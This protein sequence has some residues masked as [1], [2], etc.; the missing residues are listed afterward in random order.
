MSAPA[1]ATWPP[2]RSASAFAGASRST[3]TVVSSSRKPS[4]TAAAASAAIRSGWSTRF[5]TCAWID[6][7]RRTRIF[8]IA[9]RISTG[10]RSA[11][12]AA[13][14][15]G[16]MP[17]GQP[18]DLGARNRGIDDHPRELDRVERHR[19]LGHGQVDPVAGDELVDQVELLL[20]LPV[21]LDHAALLDPERRLGVEGA[22][23]RDQAEHR[24]LGH[25][26]VAA[27]R[28]RGVERRPGGGFVLDAHGGRLEPRG[29]DREHGRA[30]GYEESL[31]LRARLRFSIVQD[32]PEQQFLP[33]SVT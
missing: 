8:C 25:E 2:T 19:L 3:G 13:I 15:A 22:R 31:A 30:G 11:S 1:A 27:D 9:W 21:E 18:R 24:I 14:F 10:V 32:R 4:A 29:V 26:I 6:G 33:A 12:V 5:V 16:V 20:R 28:P 7:V 23:E 17:G